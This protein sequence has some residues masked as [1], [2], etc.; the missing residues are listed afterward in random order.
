MIMLAATQMTRDKEKAPG[1]DN[2]PF[3]RSKPKEYAP[4]PRNMACPRG[5]MP[6]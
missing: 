5:S 1:R 4:K 6:E 3:V 2:E